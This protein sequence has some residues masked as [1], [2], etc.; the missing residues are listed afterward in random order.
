M[1]VLQ[2]LWN[3]FLMLVDLLLWRLATNLMLRRLDTN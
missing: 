1:V 2:S 3:L